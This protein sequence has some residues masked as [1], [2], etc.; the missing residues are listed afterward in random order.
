MDSQES[1]NP[2]DVVAFIDSDVRG[3]GSPTTPVSSQDRYI[4]Y[5]IIYSNNFNELVTFKLY[6]K[7]T[8]KVSSSVT[9]PLQFIVNGNVKLF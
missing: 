9:L 1:R 7:I 2:D 5:F 6:N 3:V 8:N 4:T